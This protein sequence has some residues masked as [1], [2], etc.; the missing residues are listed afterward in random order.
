MTRHEIH[1]VLQNA[2]TLVTSLRPHADD[3]SPEVA[4]SVGECIGQLVKTKALL[5]RDIDDATRQRRSP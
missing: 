3:M 5:S 2:L 1:A 4:L